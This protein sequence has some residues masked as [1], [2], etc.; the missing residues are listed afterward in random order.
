MLRL[1]RPARGLAVRSVLRI[2]THN[3]KFCFSQYNVLHK[4][5][6]L[7]VPARQGAGRRSGDARS[8]AV[9]VRKVDN[10]IVFR[11]KI[12]GFYIEK[13]RLEPFLKLN[14]VQLERSESIQVSI[15]PPMAPM[16]ASSL[17]SSRKDD[18][19]ST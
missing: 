11:A 3:T 15:G 16:I 9:K 12:D 19:R 6:F 14:S 1:R 2:E 10:T 18:D 4:L 13:R 17:R 5:A 7:K 8:P